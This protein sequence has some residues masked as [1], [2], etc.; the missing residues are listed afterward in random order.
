[1]EKKPKS[2]KSKIKLLLKLALVGGLLYFLAKNGFIS[3]QHTG[4]AF[5]RWDKMLPAMLGLALTLVF[6]VTRWQILLRAQNMQVTWGKVFQIALIGNFFNIALPG[7]VS[8]DFVKAFYLGNEIK[9]KRAWAF[10]TILFDRVA[11]LSALVLLSAGALTLGLKSFYGTSLY[12]AIHLFVVIA[13]LCVVGFF[14][15]LFLVR[16][17]HDPVLR[18]LR[19]AEAKV[20]K[21]GSFARIYE[22]LRAFHNHRLAVVTTLLL[23]VVIHLIVGWVF[24]TFAE[25][26]GDTNLS[27]LSVYVVFPLGLLIVAI[28]VAPAGIGTGHLAYTALFGLIGSQRGADV[29]TLFALANMTFGALGGLIY[30]QFKAKSPQLDLSQSAQSP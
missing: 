13:A 9:G 26:L 14:A 4:E 23:S 28:P 22:G 18:L 6:G 30:L 19:F 15:Y 2:Y 8:G 16:E 21:L 12:S 27:L 5:A 11:G 29:F 3:M 1:M 25:A 24:L 20:S 7:A 10:G 17:H